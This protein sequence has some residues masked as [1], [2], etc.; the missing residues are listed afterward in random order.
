MSDILTILTNEGTKLV[1]KA[2][3]GVEAEAEEEGIESTLD[4]GA[5]VIFLMLIF[6]M[7]VGAY[8]EKNHIKFGHEASFTVIMGMFISFI[9]YQRD[10]QMIMDLLQFDDNA[11]FFF[12]LP[13]IIFASGFNMQRGDFF[14]N[15]SP[16][17][18]LGVIG[19]F[20]GFF[21]FSLLTIMVKRN[22]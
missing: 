18:L 21:S 3:A 7:T 15:L 17:L 19:T 16:I 10:N 20:V 5:I 13:P 6:Y 4:T 12:C 8:I 11:F 2:V 14:A 9:E 22:I 1:E